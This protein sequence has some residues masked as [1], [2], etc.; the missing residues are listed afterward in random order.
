MTPKILI[1]RFSSIGD[2]V[3]TTPV[4]RIAKQ[5]IEG[6]EVHLV[7]KNA[8]SS[9]VEANPYLD[10]VHVLENDLKA[11]IE[12]LKQ[13]GFTHVIDLHNNLRSR[14]IKKA[15]K[16]PSK[17]F[18]KL[19]IEKWLAVNFKQ[20]HR[21]PDTHIVDRYLETLSGFNIKNDQKGLDYF[22]PKKDKV[23]LKNLPESHRTGYL[24][25]V[26][27]GSYATKMLPNEKIIEVLSRIEKPVVLLGGPEDAVNGKLISEKL[28]DNVFNACGKFNI[29]QSASLV[30]Q[31]TKVLS[32][33][34][35]LMHVAAAFNKRTLSFW[36]NTIPEFGMYP[37]MPENQNKSTIMEVADLGCRPC[38]KLGHKKC[39]K[40]HF[41]CMQL[42]D[43]DKVEAWI[44]FQ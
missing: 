40:K 8:F 31:A 7:T 25:W 22:I 16:L 12:E 39:P 3:L 15:L 10:K 19:N 24:A 11:L 30:E 43:S 42:I 4:I 38:S 37:Y 13:E 29:N 44:N 21:L 17:S 6:S 41:H 28:G 1:I 14:K 27:G 9:V 5:Q 18:T 34:T 36:G 23:D 20:I 33:D 26:I 35:G 2:L 32:N